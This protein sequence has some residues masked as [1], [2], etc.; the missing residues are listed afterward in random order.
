MRLSFGVAG[1][2]AGNNRAPIKYWLPSAV[3]AVQQLQCS[4]VLTWIKWKLRPV[5][6][7]TTPRVNF[8]ST[9]NG[10]SLSARVIRQSNAETLNQH[11]I[12]SVIGKLWQKYHWHS[13]SVSW[14]ES[15][16]TSLKQAS[17][18]HYT[19]ST[20]VQSSSSL[21]KQLLSREVFYAWKA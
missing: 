21:K 14:W 19:T 7:K 1:Y 13:S 16:C 15:A 17:Q 11:R 4:V 18:W 6:L 5:R 2:E 9:V 20:K 10:I 12:E 3:N 8:S